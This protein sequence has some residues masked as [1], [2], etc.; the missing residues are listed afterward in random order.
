MADFILF[1]LFDNFFRFLALLDT[2]L[3]RLTELTTLICSL[4]LDGQPD[5][6]TNYIKLI[7]NS[8]SKIT[9]IQICQNLFYYSKFFLP[10]KFHHMFQF[11]KSNINSYTPPHLSHWNHLAAH[12]HSKHSPFIHLLFI[13]G[14][15]LCTCLQ[16]W[17]LYSCCQSFILLG[18]ILFVRSYLYY[19]PCLCLLASWRKNNFFLQ[20]RPI[21]F[22][23]MH[24]I[25][26]M[27]RRDIFQL[28]ADFFTRESKKCVCVKCAYSKPTA[29]SGSSGVT[30]TRGTSVHVYAIGA[31]AGGRP[32]ECQMLRSGRDMRRPRM[33]TPG[34]ADVNFPKSYV[35]EEWKGSIEQ[36]FRQTGANSIQY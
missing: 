22:Y 30:R 9:N 31:L 29:L 28:F 33:Q 21:F 36:F 2:S 32:S 14:I 15:S 20:K 10:L 8:A 5:F 11:R 16:L 24:F 13:F 27:A 4:L 17:L 19:S 26:S 6:R 7:T 23:P 18:T 12:K 1:W 3:S 25:L 34:R 35:A